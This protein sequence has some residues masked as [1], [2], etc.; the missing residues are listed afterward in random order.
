MKNKKMENRTEDEMNNSI[1]AGARAG[2]LLSASLAVG[3][4]I[5]AVAKADSGRNETQY[6]QI[7]LVS[8]LAGIAQV[9]DTNLVNAWGIS[10]HATFPFWVSDN[11]SGKTTLY[12]V[13]N[14]ASGGP[15]AS[16]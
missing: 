6:Q 16:I 4:C 10:Y 5:P 9:Q 12:S 14:D 7:N 8:D 3:A 11:G 13:T 15:H 1:R 2:L